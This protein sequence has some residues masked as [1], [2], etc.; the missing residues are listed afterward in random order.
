M[1]L[2]A[3]L[4]RINEPLE[5]NDKQFIFFAKYLFGDMKPLLSSKTKDGIM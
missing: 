2:V 1:R 3:F 5:D 4:K